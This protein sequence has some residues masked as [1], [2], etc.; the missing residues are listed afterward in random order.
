MKGHL[1]LVC[2]ALLLCLWGTPAEA[3]I[4]AVRDASGVLTLSDKP[5]GEGAQ[6][7]AVPGAAGYRTTVSSNGATI[8]VRPSAWDDVIEERAAAHGIRPELVR[9][10][11]QV[12]SAFNPRARSIK[13]AMGLMQLMPD[14]AAD[15]LG[16]IETA[17]GATIR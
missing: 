12:E 13:G 5:L 17:R 10:V 9:A 1:I 8:P 7:Y 4:Y 6:A 15:L 2:P 14:T 16:T 3:Q 11:I